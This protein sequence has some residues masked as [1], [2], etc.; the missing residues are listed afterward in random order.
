MA[1]VA[2]ERTPGHLWAVGLV[3]LLWNA[4]GCIDYTMTKLDPAGYMKSAGMGGEAIAYMQA[5]PA[6]LTIFWALGVWGSLAGSILLLVRSRHAVTAFAVS[7]LGLAVSQ[8]YQFTLAMPAEMRTPG[9]WLMTGLIW[10]ALLFFLWYA[11]AM[12][13]AGVLR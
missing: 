6:W 9:M 8:I 3:S 11:R 5:L 7:L 10:A 1:T 12:R 2:S 13:A 4:F